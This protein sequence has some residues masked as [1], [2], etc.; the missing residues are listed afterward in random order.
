MESRPGMRRRVRHRKQHLFPIR[1]CY[2]EIMALDKLRFHNI[3]VRGM[4]AP[5]ES[6]TDLAETVD[7]GITDATRDHATKQDVEHY[8]DKAINRLLR[9]M[10]GGGI[11]IGG[12]IIGLLIALVMRGG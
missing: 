6:A 10:I 1:L 7:S 11:A 12:S 5:S 4:G 3:L 9:W 2:A 8:I